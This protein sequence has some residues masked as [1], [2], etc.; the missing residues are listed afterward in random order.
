M[1]SQQFQSNQFNNNIPV[2]GDTCFVEGFNVLPVMFDPASAAVQLVPGDAVVLTTSD[3]TTIMVDKAAA[4]EIPFGFVLYNMQKN[5]FVP[6]DAFELARFGT[7]IY[8]QAQ[9]SISRGDDLEYVPDSVNLGN[10]DDPLMTVSGGI[11]PISAVALDNANDGD[12]FRMIIITQVDFV[13]TIVGGTI[14][15]TPIGQGTAN[16]G[17]FTVLQ[18]TTSLTVSGATITTTLADAIVALSTGP[19][20]SL[21]PTAGGLFTLVPVQSCTINAASLPTKHQR[22]VIVI[23]TSGTTAYTITFGTHFKTQGTLSTGGT[24]GKVFCLG[25]E[26]D[27]VNFNEVSGRTSM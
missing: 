10:A 24:S 27:G 14:N 19:T 9:G 18:A 15:N 23:T 20:I 13:P 26:C 21:D 3:G 7:S 12:I 4:D 1:G 17:K 5:I 2:K 25:F 22:V 11:N 16:V 6:G 8:A